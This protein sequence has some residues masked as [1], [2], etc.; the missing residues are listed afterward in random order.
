MNSVKLE[1]VLG[2]SCVNVTKNGALHIL[3]N[4]MGK[5]VKNVE[6]NRF[7]AAYGS[8]IKTK[9]YPRM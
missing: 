3:L 1:R 5:S 4:F 9:S 7:L 2:A 8:T 6:N